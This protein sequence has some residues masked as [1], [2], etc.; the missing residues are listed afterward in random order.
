[1]TTLQLKRLLINRIN[2]IDDI[3]FL[4]E[5]KSILDS[6]SKQQILKLTQ[7]QRLEIHESKKE[8]EKGYYIEQ[9][10]IDQEVERWANE[11]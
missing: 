11:K 2:E 8:I 1:M 10:E 4:N 3:A 6:K 9:S 5:I 7:E